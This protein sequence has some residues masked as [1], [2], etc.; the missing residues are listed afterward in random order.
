MPEWLDRFNDFLENS[1][2]NNTEP[3]SSSDDRRSNEDWLARRTREIMERGRVDWNRASEQAKYELLARALGP[4]G[5][6]IGPDW[7]QIREEEDNDPDGDANLRHT[8][9]S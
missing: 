6:Y 2:F 7:I 5:H 4:D 8:Y 9:L 1:V 3:D